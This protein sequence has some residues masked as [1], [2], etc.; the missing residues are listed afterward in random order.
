MTTKR[1]LPESN[2]EHIYGFD[3]DYRCDPWDRP[4]LNDQSSLTFKEHPFAPNK[5]HKAE[6][7]HNKQFMSQPFKDDNNSSNTTKKHNLPDDSPVSL[8]S[9]KEYMTEKDGD[10][11]ILIST[12]LLQKPRRLL[13]LPIEFDERTMDGLVYLETFINAMSWSDYNMIKMNSDN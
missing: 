12:T 13:Y 2:Q 5:G 10:T 9:I 4:D 7:A 1:A 11:C 6:N 8:N 3:K